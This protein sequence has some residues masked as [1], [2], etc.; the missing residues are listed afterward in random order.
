MI[1]NKE[2]ESS[3][4]YKKRNEILWIDEFDLIG[5]MK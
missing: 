3:S 4:F 5:F 1:P 2:K